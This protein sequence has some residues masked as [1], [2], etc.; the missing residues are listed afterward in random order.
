MVLFHENYR[1]C[2]KVT[3]AK[4]STDPLSGWLCTHSHREEGSCRGTQAC[5]EGDRREPQLW[6]EAS[7]A[8]LKT[9]TIPFCRYSELEM[10]KSCFKVSYL[11]TLPTLT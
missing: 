7:P 2:S 5:R 11:G 6:T 10:D 9:P 4:C 3:T 8:E 1:G